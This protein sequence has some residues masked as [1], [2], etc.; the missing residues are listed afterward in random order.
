MPLS[1]LR[2][3]LTWVRVIVVSTRVFLRPRLLVVDSAL[4]VVEEYQHKILK[5]EQAV[6]IKPNMK[7][8]RRCTFSDTIPS[9]HDTVLI[10]V[11]STHPSRRPYSS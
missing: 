7:H 3:F 9:L 10:H 11:C 6:L 2:V 5:L 1:S 8:V 4:E